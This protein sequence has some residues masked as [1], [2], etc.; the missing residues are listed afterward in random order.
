M[1]PRYGP[2]SNRIC[3]DCRPSICDV[4]GVFLLFITISNGMTKSWTL[5]WLVSPVLNPY[6]RSFCK[7]DPP[8]FIISSGLP[9]AHQ[10]TVHWDCRQHRARLTPGAILEANQRSSQG[11]LAEA[12]ESGWFYSQRTLGWFGCQGSLST[13]VTMHSGQAFLIDYIGV[14]VV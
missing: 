13:G 6:R 7:E 5:R 1:A 4:K 14:S 8:C 12:I 9:Q 3:S 10:L 11:K 2:Y